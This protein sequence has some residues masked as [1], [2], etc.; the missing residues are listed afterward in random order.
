MLLTG[1][2]SKLLV[3]VSL[4]VSQVLGLSTLLSRQLVRSF[5]DCTFLASQWVL[6]PSA[7]QPF[8][9]EQHHDKTLDSRCLCSKLN[10]RG[11]TSV[12]GLATCDSVMI[13]L[14][15]AVASDFRCLLKGRGFVK[16]TCR[17]LFTSSIVCNKGCYTPA[18][19]FD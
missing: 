9:S 4:D 19:F 16:P 1:D 17:C 2:P 6:R 12:E 7:C 11:V 15:V 5:W 18:P 3:Y 8:V 10:Q 13:S 14:L